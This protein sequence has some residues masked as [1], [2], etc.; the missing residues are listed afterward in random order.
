MTSARTAGTLFVPAHEDKK[1][2]TSAGVWVS[3]VLPSAITHAHMWVAA[4]HPP[5][6]PASAPAPSAEAP[7]TDCCL[8]ALAILCDAGSGVG[9]VL[10]TAVLLALF[11]PALHVHDRCACDALDPQTLQVVGKDAVKAMYA[12]LQLQVPSAAGVPRRLMK[13]LNAFFSSSGHAA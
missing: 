7:H 12:V 11:T 9:T 5:R 6:P 1:K 4:C 8:P 10:V 13:V 2:A 3:T